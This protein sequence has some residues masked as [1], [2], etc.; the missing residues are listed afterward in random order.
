MYLFDW[1]MIGAQ[2][3]TNPPGPPG[4][5]GGG[6]P[7]S[8]GG[9]KTNP[10]ATGTS[11]SPNADQ[12]KGWTDRWERAYQDLIKRNR[13]IPKELLKFILSKKG[14]FSTAALEDWVRKN[15]QKN[16]LNTTTAVKR[17]QEMLRSLRAIFGN[18]Y[19]PKDDMPG[20][21]MR[22]AL[23]DPETTDFVKF[24][25]KVVSRSKTFA[26]QFPGFTEWYD[27]ASRSQSFA[28]SSDAIVKFKLARDEYE[29]LYRGLMGT[30]TVDADFITNALKNSWDDTQFKLNLQSGD[31]W[32]TT[33]GAPRDEEFKRNW[34]SIFQNTQYEGVY[35][36]TLLSKYR[37]GTM[38]FQT[39]INTDI[40]DMPEIAELYPDYAGWEKEQHSLGV[41][42]D[43]V[44]IF[45]YLSEKGGMRQDF[46]T[47]YKEIMQDTNAVIPPDLLK[48]AMDGKW[49]Q[50]LFEMSVKKS[51]PGYKKTDSYKQQTASFDLY[52]KQV[53]GEGSM[54]DQAL[55]DSY[56]SGSYTSPIQLFDEIK[57]T[58]EFR[59][60]YGN[61]DVF[62]AAQHAA[63]NAAMTDP[64][65][66][67]EYQKAFYDA[68][69]SVGIAAPSGLERQ[70]FA[71]G[72]GT[73]DFTSHVEQFSKQKEAYAWQ[74]GEQ[75][76]MT[77]AID[78]GNKTAGG[79]LRKKL[80][81]A[82]KQHQQYV[83]SK[84]TGYQTQEVGGNIAT[85]I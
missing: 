78:L 85:K 6:S 79:D 21:M 49:S 62:S 56:A 74:S 66:Y 2:D 63:G 65:L 51:D 30:T 14:V 28:S 5:G 40:K 75:A 72:E 36:D 81:E 45:S 22:Y 18:D 70:F 4:S 71:S 50:N 3:A 25:A 34:D 35:N 33:I 67:K 57:D 32:K 9:T 84:F 55:A 12:I 1:P 46:S 15:D 53:F 52:W 48:Q 76:D 8:P 20:L 83:S 7:A 10:K 77:T 58:G 82:I 47:W 31:T 42:E 80:E 59:S 38:D 17:Q 41:P 44:N 24:F 61:W 60:Q 69:A 39:L 13:P 37:T 73:T 43:K 29:K 68:F 54:P 26:T 16:W 23:A 27:K 19:K 11:S 64:L